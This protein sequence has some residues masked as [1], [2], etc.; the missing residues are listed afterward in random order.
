MIKRLIGVISITL[1]TI[2]LS[3]I[4]STNTDAISANIMPGNINSSRLNHTDLHDNSALSLNSQIIEVN[5]ATAQ[6]N[7]TREYFSGKN[8]TGKEMS[9]LKNMNTYTF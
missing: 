5:L 6:K 7:F 1:V 9:S 2:F 4:S 3:L 8:I